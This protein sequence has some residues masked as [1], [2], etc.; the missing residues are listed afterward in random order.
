[1]TNDTK[2]SCVVITRLEPDV[3]LK[4]FRNKKK[5]KYK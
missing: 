5:N 1:M 2:S 4:L 3:M